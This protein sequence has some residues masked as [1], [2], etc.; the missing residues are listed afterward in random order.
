MDSSSTSRSS[1]ED[2]A[3]ERNHLAADRSLL[4]FIRS[5]LTLIGIG[6]GIEQVLSAL[7][8][9]DR[10]SAWAYG[11]SLAWVALGVLSL[12]LA[13]ADYQA[14]LRRLS[15]L[16]YRYTARWSLGEATA[17]GVLATGAVALGW[18]G[19]KAFG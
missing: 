16:S 6:L 5:S 13:V 7:S 2:L 17:I 10:S 15:A 1:Q 9:G 11:L 12:V 19:F 4:S 14:E 8:P 18:L 3:R